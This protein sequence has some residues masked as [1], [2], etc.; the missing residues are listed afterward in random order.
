MSPA[1]GLQVNGQRDALAALTQGNKA[2]THCIRGWM[3][4]KDGYGRVLNISHPLG[5]DPRTVQS[6]ATRYTDNVVPAH[7]KLLIHKCIH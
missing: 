2:G 3:G 5:F 7:V 6:V 4:S 1:P